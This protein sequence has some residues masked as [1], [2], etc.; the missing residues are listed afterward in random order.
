MKTKGSARVFVSGGLLLVALLLHFLEF[1]V[2]KDATLNL[3]SVIAG[4]PIVIKAFK[5]VRNRVFTIELLV[6]I[7][8]VGALIIGE[9]VES[10]VVTFLFLFGAYLEIR[11]LEKTRSSLQSLMDMAPQ[12]ATVVRSGESV[13]IPA[14]EIVEGDRVLIQS[15]EKV[16]VDG[17]VVSGQGYIIEAAITGESVPVKKRMEDHVFS[18]TIV[19]NGY[20]EVVAEK[21]GEDT[22][23]A[24]IIELVEEAQES[25]AKTQ[26]FLEKF[27]SFYTPGILVLSILVF[28]LTRDIRLTL[29][30]LVIACPG[31]LVISAPV[32]IV[33]GIGNGARNGILVKGGEIMEGLSKASVVVFDK[34]GTLTKGK[35]EVTAIRSFGVEEDE[36]LRLA[37]SAEVI[38]EHHLGKAIVTEAKK[39]GLEFYQAPS[40]FNVVK[41]S[42]IVAE[43]EGRKLF[44]GNRKGVVQHLEFG[45]GV[46][47]HEFVGKLAHDSLEAIPAEVEAYVRD[48]ENKGCTAIF[49]TGQSGILGVISIADQIRDDALDNIRELKGS[50]IKKTMML[51]GD[52]RRTAKLV[53]NQLGIDEVHAELLP[54]EKVEKVK[55]LRNQGYKVVMVGDGV[56]DAPAIATADIGVAMGGA[57]TDVALET[58][59]MVLMSDKLDRLSY[60]YSLSKATV[61]NMKQNMF[62]AVGIVFLLL[63][64][65]LAK[66]VYLASGMLIH[67]LSVL[68]VILNAVRLVRYN[69]GKRSIGVAAGNADGQDGLGEQKSSIGEKD[70]A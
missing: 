19:D 32:S 11:T 48:Q 33:A 16:A 2:L 20:L 50:G 64:G 31:A 17:A 54:E 30:F 41:G 58:A 44:I 68:L 15:G 37:A 69:K 6:T 5:A 24:K 53:A 57:G 59:D 26:K 3:V 28:M 49:V 62:F 18:G 45:E 40:E 34:T 66:V 10:A 12:E 43:V 47:G 27:A 21:V 42:G 65:V 46:E 36:L 35:P 1:H 63:A 55:A 52:N 25:K 51:T 7:A 56:N 60:A 22:T 39:R 70:V 67:E 14:E 8:V 23:F 29:T 13:K 38:S 9:Y 61:R 4:Y